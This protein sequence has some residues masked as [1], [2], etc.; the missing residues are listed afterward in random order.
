M[1]EL[2]MHDNFIE[3]SAVRRRKN[4]MCTVWVVSKIDTQILINSKNQQY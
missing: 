4:R 2:W 1:T 3:S